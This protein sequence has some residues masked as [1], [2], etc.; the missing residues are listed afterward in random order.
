MRGR[1]SHRCNGTKGKS[2]TPP[3]PSP[4][5]PISRMGASVSSTA[6]RCCF[7]FRLSPIVMNTTTIMCSLH[8]RSLFSDRSNTAPG[9]QSIMDAVFDRSF[10]GVVVS[11]KLSS[12]Q[13]SGKSSP[14][15][16]RR[17][18]PPVVRLSAS[19][20]KGC[21]RSSVVMTG[22]FGSSEPTS[23]A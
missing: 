9:D 11:K 12:S 4:M 13:L 23:L 14:H 2:T 20:V 19:T 18:R 17:S 15:T 6:A 22:L 3:G 21:H 16:G 5:C 1:Q 10:G 8:H 7:L